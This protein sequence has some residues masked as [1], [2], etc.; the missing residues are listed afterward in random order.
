MI[1]T[2]ISFDPGKDGAISV[3]DSETKEILWILDMPTY[4]ADV[5]G[6]K[7]SLPDWDVIDG[8][9]V[10][11]MV[12]FPGPH[13]FVTEKL[14]PQNGPRSTGQ[15]NFNLGFF[16]GAFE[17]TAKHL[18]YTYTQISPSTWQNYYGITNRGRK[19]MG[20]KEIDTKEEA[21]K[22]CLKL[23]PDLEYKTP[24][25]RILDGR[26]DSVLLGRYFIETKL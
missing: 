21:M 25:G 5:S 1:R 24:R 2:I 4:N 3:I 8:H 9:I 16:K 7:R 14:W 13:H 6:K 22:V 20:L 12:K 26:F 18:G 17:R 15:S 11:L 23:Y 10:G 19:K